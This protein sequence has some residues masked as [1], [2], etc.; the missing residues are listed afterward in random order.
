MANKF[1]SLEKEN[2]ENESKQPNAAEEQPESPSNIKQE[3]PREQDKPDDDF[4][5]PS[6]SQEQKE[7][8]PPQAPGD[9]AAALSYATDLLH[10][11]LSVGTGYPGWELDDHEK[12][13]WQSFWSQV[14]PFIAFKYLGLVLA[15]VMIGIIEMIKTGQCMRW[16]KGAN[17]A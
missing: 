12:Q 9:L 10:H 7:E 6:E 3:E 15:I 14:M 13:V 16:R 5:H 1:G 2:K 8:P 11:E 17:P 4:W